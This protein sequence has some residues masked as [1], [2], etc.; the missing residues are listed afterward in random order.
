MNDNLRELIKYK[1]FLKNLVLK[2]LRIRYKRSILGYFWTMLNPL[3]MMIV[4][5]VIFSLLLR[6]D[7]KNYSVYL[8]TGILPWNFFVQSV[9]ISNMSIITNAGLIKKV[10]VPKV[11]FPISN[12]TSNL[13]NFLL[14]IIPLFL[15]MP[16]LG[17]NIDIS[18]L[19]LPVPIAILFVF[20]CGLSLIF[21]TLNVF[22]RDMSHIIEVIFQLWFY[23]TPIIYP[24]TAIPE[25]YRLLF[26]YNPMY[27]FIKCFQDPLY[28]HF[29][30]DAQTLLV[31]FLLAVFTY[32]FGW[33]FFHKCENN[34]I[35]YL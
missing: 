21:A 8:I 3:L 6:F 30:P 20:T 14:A 24:I 27:Y 13:V 1:E 7:M 34:F 25:K 28:N 12:V 15:L 22:F 33:W 26:K 18:A 35:H 19:Y 17:V 5:S 29:L 23:L 11:I 2:D 32:L 4:F 10:Y 9:I 16:I 31:A